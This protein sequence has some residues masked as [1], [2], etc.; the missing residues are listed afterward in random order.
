MASSGSAPLP[1]ACSLHYPTVSRAVVLLVLLSNCVTGTIATIREM[2]RCGKRRLF[3]QSTLILK[4]INL[5]RQARDRHRRSWVE[6]NKEVAFSLQGGGRFQV[7]A[8]RIFLQG[9]WAGAKNA[10]F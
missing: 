1:R 5:P 7:R 10:T 9:R 4:P 8:A 6:F 3:G 2:L